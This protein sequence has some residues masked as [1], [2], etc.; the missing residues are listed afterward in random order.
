MPCPW[1]APALYVTEP[2][3]EAKSR[4]VR[5]KPQG[6]AWGNACIDWRKR[7]GAAWCLRSHSGTAASVG[8]MSYARSVDVHGA[9]TGSRI[10]GLVTADSVTGLITGSHR[11]G[12]AVGAERD[13][14]AEAIT[15]FGVGGFHI[16]LL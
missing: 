6:G 12:A 11:E 2:R 1:N 9:R 14:N 15:S 8:P 3:R 16:I 13:R 10:V 4:R 7:V 5:I